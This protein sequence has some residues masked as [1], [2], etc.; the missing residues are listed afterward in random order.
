M[1]ERWKE[2][3]RKQRAALRE[4]NRSTALLAAEVSGQTVEREE[5]GSGA[6]AAC[7]TACCPRP[8]ERRTRRGSDA[9]AEPSPAPA[10]GDKQKFGPAGRP[11][12]RQSPFYVGFIG[13]VGVL[14]ALGLWHT[15][16]RLT[17]VITLLV[18]ALFLTLA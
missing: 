7:S 17:T 11:L 8:R 6:T 3:R 9:P 16:G 12:N 15:L 14:V 18:V 10:E 13:A 2:F 1:L 5:G 4:S